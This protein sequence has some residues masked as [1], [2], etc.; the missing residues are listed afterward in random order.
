MNRELI[1]REYVVSKIAHHIHQK[2]LTTTGKEPWKNGKAA[3]WAY[4]YAEVAVDILG[5]DDDVL[6]RLDGGE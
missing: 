6:S 1:E 5:W 2:Y 3:P 4:E